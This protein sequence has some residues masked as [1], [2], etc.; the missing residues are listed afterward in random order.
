MSSSTTSQTPAGEE[1]SNQRKA[2]S[3]VREER[4]AERENKEERK[5][6]RVH[7]VSTLRCHNL[8]NTAGSEVED[9]LVSVAH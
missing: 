3:P 8:V 4:R 2:I 7:M 1:I 5:R 6:R 9:E